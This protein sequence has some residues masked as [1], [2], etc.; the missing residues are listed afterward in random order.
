LE[1]KSE[2][3]VGT[4]RV[5]AITLELLNSGAIVGSLAMTFSTLLL[6]LT[7]PRAKRLNRIALLAE[8]AKS[9]EP[10]EQMQFGGLNC[11]CDRLTTE[12]VQ[13]AHDLR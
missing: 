5:L 6:Q 11:H 10:V 2:I 9:H 3:P 12:R 7:D 4:C 8:S 13:F 1:E